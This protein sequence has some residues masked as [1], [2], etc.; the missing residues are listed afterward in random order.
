MKTSRR[1]QIFEIV[2]TM[3]EPFS[4]HDVRDLAETQGLSTGNVENA[5]YFFKKLGWILMLDNPNRQ[6]NE[7]ASYHRHRWP[8]TYTDGFRPNQDGNLKAITP[9]PY[10]PHIPQTPMQILHAQIRA[11]LDS[12]TTPL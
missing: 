6:H 5:L 8:K 1:Q 7:P 4:S 11:E 9:K 12:T 3:A 10:I 2:A